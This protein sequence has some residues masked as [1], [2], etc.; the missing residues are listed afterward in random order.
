MTDHDSESAARRALEAVGGPLTLTPKLT[1]DCE[2]H[3]TVEYVRRVRTS[4]GT[5]EFAPDHVSGYGLLKCL[6]AMEKRLREQDAALLRHLQSR[7]TQEE[8]VPS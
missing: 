2:L 7:P 3:W 6:E 4:A 8:T 1:G 5:V